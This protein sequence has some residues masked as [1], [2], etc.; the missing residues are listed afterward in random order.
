MANEPKRGKSE[1][2]WRKK[3]AK[4]YPGP[5]LSDHLVFTVETKGKQEV[6]RAF[7]RKTGDQRVGAEWAGSMSRSFLR[8]E[9]R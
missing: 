9:K 5:V 6:V 4:G 3:I 2:K 8:L 1:P 7:D